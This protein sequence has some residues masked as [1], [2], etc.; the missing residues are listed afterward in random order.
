MQN[1]FPSTGGANFIP[2]LYALG[3]GPEKA[4][5]MIA[6]VATALFNS[7][8]NGNQKRA[9]ASLSRARDEPNSKVRERTAELERVRRSRRASA[10]V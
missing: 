1:S 2:P 10:W 8:L 6:F 9:K 4:P 5:D 7:W 3:I